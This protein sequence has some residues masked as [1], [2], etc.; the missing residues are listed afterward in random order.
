MSNG[1]KKD[2]EKFTYMS[3]VVTFTHKEERKND[4]VSKKRPQCEVKGAT[5]MVMC[6]MR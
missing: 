5:R 6:D 2:C 1:L 3:K 4:G